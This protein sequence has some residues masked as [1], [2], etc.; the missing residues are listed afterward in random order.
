MS[1]L[2]ISLAAFV[3][4]FGGALAGVWIARRLP[5]HHQNAET[6]NAIS[7]SMAV[8]GTLA[9]LVLGLMISTASS[10]FRTRADA[11]Q[12]LAL[13]IVKLNRT[14]QRYGPEAAGV[15]TALQSYA[16]A[17][18]HELSEGAGAS[19]LG[20]RTLA[21]LETVNDEILELRP[22]DDRLRHIQARAIQL[23]DSIGDARWLLIEHSGTAIP[24]PFLILLIFWLT[25]LFASFG[26]FAPK[27]LTVIV[28][29]LLCAIAIS[30]GILMILE[31]GSPSSGLIRASVAP[32]DRAITEISTGTN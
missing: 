2:F 24:P 14:L 28:A 1:S 19:G 25:L 23:A 3:A 5:E 12:N 22:G 21:M 10:S 26:L 17:K 15:Q 27:N 31:L 6:R 29:L 8:V 4:I 9:A 16:R 18:T 32:M 13:D 20:L 30:G 7:L 11:I